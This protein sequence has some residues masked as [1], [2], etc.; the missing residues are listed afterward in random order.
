MNKQQAIAVLMRQQHQIDSLV[1]LPYYGDGEDFPVPF[2]KWRRDTRIAIKNIFGADTGHLAEFKD[3]SYYNNHQDDV[4]AYKLGLEHARVMLQSMAEE[5]ADYWN[6]DMFPI[7]SATAE[8]NEAGQGVPATRKVFVVHGHDHGFKEAV[9]RVLTT[10]E[11][12][13]IILHEQPDQGKTIMEKFSDY[14]D[15]SFAIAL[16]TPDDLGEAKDKVDN[17]KP[18]ARQNVIFEFGY[19]IGKLGRSNACGLT[20][21]RVDTP[22]DY[23]GVLYISFDDAGHWKFRLA[24]ELRA[25]GFDIDANKLL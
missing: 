23:S 13:P 25:A 19:F 10:L 4:E 6:D 9:A 12:D 15:V 20:K 22:S 1:A 17:L 24:G 7:P 2:H 18:R 8:R 14:S 3:I 21:G 11:M 16:L 5:V